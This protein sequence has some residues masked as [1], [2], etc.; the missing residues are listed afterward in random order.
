MVCYLS[1]GI[2]S[3]HPQ[4]SLAD[5]RSSYKPALIAAWFLTSCPEDT[6]AHLCPCEPPCSVRI[7]LR[8]CPAPLLLL[9]VQH[10]YATPHNKAD[11]A[12]AEVLEHAVRT[13]VCRSWKPKAHPQQVNLPSCRRRMLFFGQECTGNR[14]GVFSCSPDLCLP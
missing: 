1:P 4:Q 8:L 13:E 9:F 11:C 2:K 5:T 10:L 3:L 12:N 6:S 14:A 7:F